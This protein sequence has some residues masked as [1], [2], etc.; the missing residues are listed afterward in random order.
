MFFLTHSILGENIA[1]EVRWRTRK[2][3]CM[4]VLNIYTSTTKHIFHSFFFLLPSNPNTGTGKIQYAMSQ[5]RNC[6]ISTYGL[7]IQVVNI[8]LFLCFRI[9]VMPRI[10]ILGTSPLELLKIGVY[11][12]FAYDGQ[13]NICHQTKHIFHSFFFLLASNPNTGTRNIQYTMRQA[14]NCDILT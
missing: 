11:C 13:T 1:F 5:A 12:F 7:W 4:C 14:L 6:N 3:C 8:F 10:Q 2:M 9:R